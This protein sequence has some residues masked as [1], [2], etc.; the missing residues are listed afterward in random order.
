MNSAT[1]KSKFVEQNIV[2]LKNGKW[3]LYTGSYVLDMYYNTS[4]A[5][6]IDIFVPFYYN[7]QGLQLD[8]EFILTQLDYNKNQYQLEF[9]HGWY[10]NIENKLISVN[11]RHF[12]GHKVNITFMIVND[13][14]ISK[15][16][17]HKIL[18]E[19]FD[20][21]ICSIAWDGEK[22]YLPPSEL[23]DLANKRTTVRDD[24]I[25]ETKG[26]KRMLKY[27]E[28]NFRMFTNGYQKEYLF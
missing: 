23:V 10:D 2:R 11:I 27:V 21:K 6:D 17:F 12:N 25:E 22:L 15:E 26:L 19:K 20:I 14:D 5:N 3:G 9:L 16:E 24:I 18:V 13:P 7:R 8:E 1:F 28:R 4:L